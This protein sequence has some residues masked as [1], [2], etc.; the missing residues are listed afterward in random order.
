MEEGKGKSTKVPPVA[1]TPPVFTIRADSKFGIKAMIA[2]T[3]IAEQGLTLDEQRTVKAKLREFDIYEEL[4]R[5]L[6]EYV[7]LPDGR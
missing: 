4:N 1:T 5:P 6:P 2:V 7:S 3:H